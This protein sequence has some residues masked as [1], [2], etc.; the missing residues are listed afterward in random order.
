MCNIFFKIL[1]L[2]GKFRDFSTRRSNSHTLGGGGV[3]GQGKGQ[4]LMSIFAVID[5]NWLAT[6]QKKIYKKYPPVERLQN[7]PLRYPV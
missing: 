5:Y 4:R 7:L 6:C 1:T 2:V 3:Q